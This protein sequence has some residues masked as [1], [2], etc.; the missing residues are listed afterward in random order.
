MGAQDVPI[1]SYQFCCDLK[2]ALKNCL[3]NITKH[4]IHVLPLK[5]FEVMGKVNDCTKRRK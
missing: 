4:N 1:A 2:T 3:K 5:Y